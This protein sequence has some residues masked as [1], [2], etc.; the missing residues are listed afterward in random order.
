MKVLY[1]IIISLC[2]AKN[3]NFM[4]LTKEEKLKD[5]KDPEDPKEGSL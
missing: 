1:F 5:Q 4:E 3:V 2:L